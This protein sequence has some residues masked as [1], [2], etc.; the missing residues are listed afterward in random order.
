MNAP[1]PDRVTDDR[2]AQAEAFTVALLDG[3]LRCDKSGVAVL[4]LLAALRNFHQLRDF[5]HQERFG[6]PDGQARQALSQL[7]ELQQSLRELVAD[8]S[9]SDDEVLSQRSSHK[10]RLSGP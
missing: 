10:G 9:G 6:A 8:M 5:S 7:G 4:E 1:I 2:A 3:P